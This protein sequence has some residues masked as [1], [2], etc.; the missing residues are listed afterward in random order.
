MNIGQRKKHKAWKSFVVGGVAILA[1][2]VALYVVVNFEKIQSQLAHYLS[3]DTSTLVNAKKYKQKKKPSY[4]L[5]KVE[6]ISPASLASAWQHRQD[7]RAVGQVAVANAHVLLNIYRG[8]G[9]NELALGAGTFRANQ[10]MGINNY[11][12]AAHNM[13]DGRTYFSPLYTAKVRGTLRNGTPIFITD[14]KKVYYY[15]ITTSRFISVQNLSLSYN[16][17]K[18]KKTP[19][20]TLFT[21]DWTGHGRLYIKG[22]LTGSQSIT[23]CSK[24]VR[25]CFAID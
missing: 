5:N 19:V 16:H 2:I 23:S 20:I 17:K 11:P 13:D 3:A 8:V 7:Y 12:L 9:N 18:Y 4:N 1:L 15:K 24:Y 14:F 6:P 21:C 25:S 22:E 10:K